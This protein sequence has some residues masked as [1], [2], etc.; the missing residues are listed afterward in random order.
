[1]YS[2]ICS[3]CLSRLSVVK[4]KVAQAIN[5]ST[6][7]ARRKYDL[8]GMFPHRIAPSSTEKPHKKKLTNSDLP[9]SM[10]SSDTGMHFVQIHVAVV[11][12]T[13]DA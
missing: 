6:R 5:L 13:G 2:K 9:D 11:K 3:A 7:P 12:D 8:G 1:M 10:N 4:E